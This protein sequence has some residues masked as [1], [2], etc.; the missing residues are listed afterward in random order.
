MQ[1]LQVNKSTILFLGA[2]LT[3]LLSGCSTFGPSDPISTQAHAVISQAERQGFVPMLY[4]T[5]LVTYAVW[6]KNKQDSH[7][8]ING[9]ATLAKQENHQRYNRDSQNNWDIHLYI[10]GDGN[11]WKTRY[12]LSDNPTPKNPLTLKLAMQDANANVIY[13]ARPCQYHFDSAKCK[14][15]YWS[16]ARYSEEVIQSTNEVL[17]QI[18]ARHPRA[19]FL[20][21]GFSGGGNIAAL[22]SARRDDV[23]GLITIAGNLD[24]DALSEYHH[25]TPMRAS[26][27]AIHYANELKNIP[28]KHYVGSKDKIVPAWL[29]KKYTQSLN[30]PCVSMEIIKGNTHHKGWEEK[31]PQFLK[32]AL[33]CQP[34]TI[35][36]NS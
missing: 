12:Q 16:D 9:T 18:K 3:S 29:T 8:K 1:M 22:L 34:N 27:N 10:E 25:V 17:T 11:S 20:L 36:K 32:E 7:S 35:T 14:S 5:S 28:Q 4:D 6:E 24:H 26:L 23:S 15:R 13:I 30:S 33:P 31:W 21:I 2:A 19:R